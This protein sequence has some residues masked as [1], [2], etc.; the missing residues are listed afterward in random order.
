MNE[1]TFCSIMKLESNKSIGVLGSIEGE[2]G[3]YAGCFEV[4]RL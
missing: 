4:Y 3:Y 2:E 1:R